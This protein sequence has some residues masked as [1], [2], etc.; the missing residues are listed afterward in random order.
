MVFYVNSTK[1]AKITQYFMMVVII[2]VF[3]SCQKFKH[4][5]PAG[6]FKIHPT[7]FNTSSYG[8]AIFHD[9]K[10]QEL[11]FSPHGAKIYEINYTEDF[12][13]SSEHII[14]ENQLDAHGISLFDTNFDAKLDLVISTGARKGTKPGKGNKIF[15]R[16]N[17]K[18]KA[19]KFPKASMIDKRGRTRSILPIDANLDGSLDIFI[20]NYSPKKFN[21]NQLFYSNPKTIDYNKVE[22]PN[23]LLTTFSSHFTQCHLNQ[24]LPVI[25]GQFQGTDSGKVFGANPINSNYRSINSDLNLPD[26]IKGSRVIK[27]VDIDHD[28]DFDLLVGHDLG[29][30]N[31]YFSL[32]PFDGSKF[33]APIEFPI[34]HPVSAVF[35]TDLDNNGNNEIIVCSVYQGVSTIH[36]IEISNYSQME[37]NLVST[38]IEVPDSIAS[39]VV[40]DINKDGLQDLFLYSGYK[41]SKGD[42][43]LLENTIESTNNYI[44]IS[45]EGPMGNIDNH[46][47]IINITYCGQKQT[48]QKEIGNTYYGHYESPIHI[49][50][51]DCKKYTVDVD[52]WSTR[53]NSTFKLST[54]NTTLSLNE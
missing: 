36:Q 5:K 2:I 42:H 30:R 1:E 41:E 20:V 17:G 47:S 23:K 7:D 3:I 31:S 27:S 44:D 37:S 15:E 35:I 32:Y 6:P 54:V 13:C 50:L 43:Y 26:R 40:L 10:N 38:L 25:I 18:W 33:G 46:L 51:G 11:I 52:W 39:G 53:N 19:K 21:Q 34:E 28:G 4:P 48:I 14:S 45:L 16:K 8:C 9:K 22:T 49:G 24:D 29:D 12:D